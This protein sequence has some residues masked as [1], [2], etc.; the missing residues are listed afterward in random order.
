M[1]KDYIHITFV[2]DKS[3]SM[4]TSKKDVISGFEKIISDSDLHRKYEYEVLRPYRDKVIE[5]ELV[6]CLERALITDKGTPV[7]DKMI[8]N[9]FKARTDWE[10]NAELNGG[11]SSGDTYREIFHRDAGTVKEEDTLLCK[12]KQRCKDII[13]AAKDHTETNTKPEVAKNKGYVIGATIVGILGILY[14]I[15]SGVKNHKSNSQPAE[16]IK[17]YEADEIEE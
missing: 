9:L 3:G 4:S 10:G 7:Q 12:I 1:K 13:E 14:G 5:C 6:D 8:T 2:I 15:F 17:E 16:Q 11:K